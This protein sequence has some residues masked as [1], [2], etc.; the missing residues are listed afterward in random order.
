MLSADETLRKEMEKMF[1]LISRRIDGVLEIVYGNDL[2]T[3]AL[4]VAMKIARVLST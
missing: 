1:N 3:R 2:A 4:N